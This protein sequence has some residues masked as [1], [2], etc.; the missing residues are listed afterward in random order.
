MLRMPI[1]ESYPTPQVTHL[2][3]QVSVSESNA[4]AFETYAVGSRDDAPN[5]GELSGPELHRRLLQLVA[6]HTLSSGNSLAP[7]PAL[8]A[9]S[10]AIVP[11]PWRVPP[12][13]IPR[14]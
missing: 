3:I 14:T 2:L 1:F 7:Y 9:G 4:R 5:V 12:S 11:R 8:F 6:Y 10:P 13:E